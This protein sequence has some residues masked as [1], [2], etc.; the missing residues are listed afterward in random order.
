MPLILVICGVAPSKLSA[1]APLVPKIGLKLMAA[2]SSVVTASPAVSLT[3]V[4]LMLKL[5]VLLLVCDTEIA[6]KKLPTLPLPV[7]LETAEKL[8]RKTLPD[9]TPGTTNT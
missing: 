9:A 1:D 5:F 6:S 2:P 7:A 4:T 3:G 8:I